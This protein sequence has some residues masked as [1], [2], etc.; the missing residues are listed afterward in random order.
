MLAALWLIPF[1]PLAGAAV[2]MLVG[3]RAGRRACALV[4]VGGVTGSALLSLLVLAALVARMG[5][6]PV[7]VQR[8]WTWLA[9]VDVGIAFRLDALSATMIATVSVVGALIHL[10]SAEYMAAAEVAVGLALL[11]RF[12]HDHRR[13][14]GDEAST[15]K[16]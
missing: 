6:H 8:L 13:L 5:S 11:L 14:D 10:Y 9:A 15:M 3:R 4:G 16:G 2:L 1:L 12:H 7:F